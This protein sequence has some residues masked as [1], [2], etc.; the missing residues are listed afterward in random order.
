MHT[1]IDPMHLTNNAGTKAQTND[2][3]LTCQSCTNE[4]DSHQQYIMF[5]LVEVVCIY[6]VM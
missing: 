3:L 6:T 4:P 2:I 1:D 5:F